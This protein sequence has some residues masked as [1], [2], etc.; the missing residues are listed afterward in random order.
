MGLHG[1]AQPSGLPV[2]LHDLLYSA[3]RIRFAPLRLE[4][5][6]LVWVCREMCPE[7]QAEGLRKQNGA[8]L[9]PLSLATDNRSYPWGRPSGK[10]PHHKGITLADWRAPPPTISG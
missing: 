10:Q 7:H 4:Q 3:N 6:H 8:I 5:M 9:A 2:A 1:G